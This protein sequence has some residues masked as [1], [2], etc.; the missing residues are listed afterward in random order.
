[1]N[2]AGSAALLQ[3]NGCVS[4]GLG[5]RTVCRVGS[6]EG[7]ERQT[8]S[9]PP[10]PS[11]PP[12]QP[13]PEETRHSSPTGKD[14]LPARHSPVRP[15]PRR[16]KQTR[17]T[18]APRSL[19]RSLTH[20]NRPSLHQPGPPPDLQADRR[21][22]HPP[23]YCQGGPRP[24]GACI[25]ATSGLPPGR[26]QRWEFWRRSKHT[27]PKCWRRHPSPVLYE[28]TSSTSWHWNKHV[29]QRARGW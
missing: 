10:V 28:R 18:T 3:A 20:M 16:L 15:R 19:A 12:R 26:T 29:V 2:P 14:H 9:L 17:G 8:F 22:G 24:R 4:A 11:P 23:I 5:G 13:R 7:R 1:M 27:H 25:L 21:C 6:A